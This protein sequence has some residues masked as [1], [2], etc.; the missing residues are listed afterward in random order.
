MINRNERK[1]KH[2]RPHRYEKDVRGNTI[3]LKI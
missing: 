1:D 2:Y 3:N